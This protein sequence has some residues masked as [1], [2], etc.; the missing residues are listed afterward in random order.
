MELHVTAI[1]RRHLKW[2]VGQ[3]VIGDVGDSRL[4]HGDGRLES[5]P[6]LDKPDATKLGNGADE[7]SIG[8]VALCL[9]SHYRSCTAASV[10]C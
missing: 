8:E 9:S 3:D 5:T 1:P 4:S 6:P 7:L 2:I 10:L